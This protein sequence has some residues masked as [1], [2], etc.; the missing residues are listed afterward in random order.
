MSGAKE[1]IEQQLRFAIRDYERKRRQA[2]TQEQKLKAEGA[3]EALKD[4]QAWVMGGN[5]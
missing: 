3:L 1:S 5:L 4:L 2:S